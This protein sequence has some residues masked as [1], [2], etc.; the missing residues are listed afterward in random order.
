MAKTAEF[1]FRQKYRLPPTDPRYLGMT[2]EGMLS[3]FWAHHYFDNPKAAE[4][5][6]EDEDFDM[7]EELRRLENNPDE[8]EPLT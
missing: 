8:W 5:E 1:W 6:I 3:E 4:Q 2:V 7:E